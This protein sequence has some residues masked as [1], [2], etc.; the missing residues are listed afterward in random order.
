M[1]RKLTIGFFCAF[2]LA[3]AS[4]FAADA[5]VNW[6][7][8]CAKCHGADGKGQTKMGRQSGALDYT[9]PKVQAEIK[10]DNAFKAI[11]DGLTIKGKEVMKPTGDKFSDEEI[12]DL[13][14]YVRTFVKK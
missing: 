10:D 6:D 7:K 14:A 12:K 9:D 2:L 13:V 8:N 4:T 3:S 5:K 1:K 11:K